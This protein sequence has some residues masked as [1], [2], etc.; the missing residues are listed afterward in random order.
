MNKRGITLL[1]L[2]GLVVCSSNTIF[3][4]SILEKATPTPLTLVLPTAPTTTAGSLDADTIYSLLTAE[5]AGQRDQ[6]D[7]SFDNYFN[8]AKKTKDPVIAERA[9]NIALEMRDSARILE[10]AELW[11]ALAPDNINPRTILIQQLAKANRYS[12]ISPH[13]DAILKTK[14]DADLQAIAMGAEDLTPD[15]LKQLIEVLVKTSVKY[16]KNISLHLTIARLSMVDKKWDQAQKELSAVLAIEPLQE[17]ALLM[18]SDVLLQQQKSALAVSKLHDAINRGAKSKRV[19]IYY[20]RLLLEDKQIEKAKKQFSHLA[21]LYPNDS[22]LLFTIA[23]LALDS[24]MKKVAQDYFKIVI[25]LGEHE[26]EARYYLGQIAEDDKKLDEAMAQYNQI[27]A[28]SDVYLSGVASTALIL[29]KQGK[30]DVAI[31]KIQ[32]SRN[33]NPELDIDLSLIESDLLIKQ[34]RY[35]DAIGVLTQAL[36]KN[37]DQPEL[38]YVRSLAAEKA[39]DLKMAE[40]DLRILINKNPNDAMALNA[41]GYTLADRTNRTQEALTLI[42]KALTLR[43]DDPAIIDSMGWVQFRLGNYPKALDYLRKAYKLFRDPEVAAHLGEVLWVT[44]KHDEATQL[45]SEA[46]KEN[47]DSKILKN[48]IERLKKPSK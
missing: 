10:A 20:A 40:N 33:L 26:S 19:Q 42:T 2:L 9:T 23:L 12:E 45:L 15:K 1:P 3:A 39:G 47:P 29:L 43:P 46:L 11:V 25:A 16:P 22:E 21:E 37:K 24:N 8:Q 17:Q 41:L 14:P 31:E 27:T 38:L 5:L 35:K 7:I 32:Q 18:Q 4:G 36:T 48:T 34:E 6:L 28:D 44:G 13:L 30:N